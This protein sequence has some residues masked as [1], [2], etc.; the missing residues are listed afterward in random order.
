[1]TLEEAVGGGYMPSPFMWCDK[2]GPA[3]PDFESQ[4]MKIEFDAMSLFKTLHQKGIFCR[5]IREALG[6]DKGTRITEDF[7]HR[8]FAKL[9]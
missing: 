8:F 9:L 1:M 4:K 7:A 5:R 6:I 3:D 2:H